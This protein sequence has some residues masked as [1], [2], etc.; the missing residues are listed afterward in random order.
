VSDINCTDASVDGFRK[1]QAEI[2]K[3]VRHTDDLIQDIIPGDA[4][5]PPKE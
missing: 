4:P 2:L 5:P 1:D 3:S